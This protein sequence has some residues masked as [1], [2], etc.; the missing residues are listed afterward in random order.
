M[1]IR[2]EYRS[3]ALMYLANRLRHFLVLVEHA[4]DVFLDFFKL[5]TQ[6]GDFYFRVIDQVCHPLHAVAELDVSASSASTGS[7]DADS[8]DVLAERAEESRLVFRVLGCR[9]SR[10]VWRLAIYVDVFNPRSELMVY[11]VELFGHRACLILSVDIYRLCDTLSV[12]G[13]LSTSVDSHTFHVEIDRVTLCSD[14]HFVLDA[15]A[16]A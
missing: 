2:E 9:M 7:S 15:E 10:C 13:S 11:R 3:S 12:R 4:V 6:T 8:Q 1:D 16:L 14:G 5:S